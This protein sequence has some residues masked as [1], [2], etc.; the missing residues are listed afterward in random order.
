MAIAD[1]DIERLRESVSIVDTIQGYVQLRR[2]GR[3]WVGLCPFHAEKSGSFN[4][5]EETRRYKCFGCGASGDVFKF[6]QEI[7]H[8]DFVGAIEHIAGKAG[9]QLTYTSGGQSKDRQRSKKLTEI[10]SQAVEWYHNRL[11]TAPDA[12]AAR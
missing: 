7:E 6:I 10:V 12:R 9:Y 3:N 1:T 8:L 4:V 11:L 2:V 5:R